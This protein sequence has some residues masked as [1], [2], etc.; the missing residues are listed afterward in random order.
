MPFRL[1]PLMAVLVYL[2]MSLTI[3]FP[4]NTMM[5]Q[6][7]IKHSFEWRRY[8]GNPVF[9]AVPGTWME[10]QTANPDLLLI[11]DTYHMYFRGQQGGHDRIGLA[12]IQKDQFD[13]FS[14]SIMPHPVIDVGEPGSW[15]ETHVLD[16]AAVLI[17]G[18]VYLYY[19]AVSPRSDRAVCMA[20]SDDGV[21]FRKYDENPVIIGGA[22][23]VVVR[24]SVLYLFF[25]KRKPEGPGY[26]IHLATSRDGFTFT[27]YQSEPVLPVGRKGLW[28][29]HTVETPRIF[30][31]GG[32]YYM[33]YCGS[34]RHNDYPADA[35]VATSNDLIHWEKYTGN[36]V[37]SRGPEG[38][39]D[40]GAIWFTT[41]E[42][43]DGRYYMWY[44]GYGGGEARTK[45]YG[46]Y[47]KGGK[48]Q[49][50]MAILDA[51]YFYHRSH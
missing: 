42:N 15:D 33:M 50:G 4:G 26:Q 19:S 43:I 11:D 6:G 23:E 31:E 20:V 25:W 28:D 36:P 12:T 21:R 18:R 7:K 35:G 24:D 1:V 48:S 9:P 40:E 10:D 37:F 8:E 3:V 47:L 29:S 14:W 22:P 49:I 39:W 51:P 16:P 41:V 2:A 5:T 38:A 13:G 34:D 44:E 46:S 45:P 32:L 30:S 27:E 17:N